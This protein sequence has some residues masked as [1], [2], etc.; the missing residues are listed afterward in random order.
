MFTIMEK[1]QV[2]ALGVEISGPYT[3][4]DEA[5]FEKA[6]EDAFQ[7]HEKV[8]VLVKID[9]L[10]LAQSS[11]GALFNDARYSLRKIA[12]LGHIAIVGTSRVEKALASLDNKIFGN[13]AE[14]RIEK[15]FDLAELDAAWAFIKE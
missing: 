6:F 4:E 13:P 15:Y 8:N 11:V 1:T 3:K 7:G 10:D 9:A 2:N 5:A 14:G 12:N